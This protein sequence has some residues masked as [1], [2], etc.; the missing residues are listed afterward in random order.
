[1]FYKST[2]KPDFS[3][4]KIVSKFIVSLENMCGMDYNIV[5]CKKLYFFLFL[6]Y[7]SIE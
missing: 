4:S 2:R 3:S 6:L 7:F 5:D 1:M